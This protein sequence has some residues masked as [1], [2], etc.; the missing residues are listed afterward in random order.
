MDN[1]DSVNSPPTTK[2][3]S[4]PSSNLDLLDLL[5]KIWNL[6]NEFSV[7]QPNKIHLQ[8]A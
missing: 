8:V 3:N 7:Y 2:V 4:G 6:L 1:F 5:G